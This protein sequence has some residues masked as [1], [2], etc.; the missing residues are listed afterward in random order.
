MRRNVRILCGVFDS[1]AIRLEKNK[2]REIDTSD[3]W[4]QHQSEEQSRAIF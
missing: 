4:R 1:L 2:K 3:D